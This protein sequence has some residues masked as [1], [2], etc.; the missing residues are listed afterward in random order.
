MSFTVNAVYEN[1]VLKLTQTLPLQ[2]QEKVRVT[3]EPDISWVERT[4]GMLRWTG[5]HE[6]L[7]RLVGGR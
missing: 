2:E 6:T 1:G 3:I 7:R 5:D 4:A